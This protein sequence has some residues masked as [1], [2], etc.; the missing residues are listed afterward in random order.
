MTLWIIVG[1][2]VLYFAIR[3]FFGSRRS[4]FYGDS[5]SKPSK[6]DGYEKSMNPYKSSRNHFGGG[7][8][9]N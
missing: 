3:I 6:K 5:V 7:S 2:V 4:E 8:G 1:I 9:D